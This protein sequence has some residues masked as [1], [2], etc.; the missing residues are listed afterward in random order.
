[1]SQRVRSSRKWQNTFKALSLANE[2]IGEPIAKQFQI[3]DSD[4]PADVEA[5]FSPGANDLQKKQAREFLDYCFVG[6]G[7]DLTVERGDAYYD[8]PR[9]FLSDTEKLRR[10]TAIEQVYET[11]G[12]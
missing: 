11:L 8:K 1:M 4:E 10:R 6:E 3:A 5:M 12:I 9:Q 7:F 2:A